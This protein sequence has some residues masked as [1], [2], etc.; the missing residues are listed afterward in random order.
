ME[1]L[2]NYYYDGTIPLSGS[3][4]W[5]RKFGG[6]EEQV[7]ITEFIFDVGYLASIEKELDRIV[8]N[9]RRDLSTD[10]FAE[11]DID[12]LRR[13]NTVD[14]FHQK[15]KKV[16][17]YTDQLGWF[18]PIFTHLSELLMGCR[19]EREIIENGISVFNTFDEFK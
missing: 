1:R 17:E 7:G 9:L 16:N 2:I 3:T 5:A 6:E 10:Q 11:L 12:A 4:S 19:I 13:C 8:D 18:N 14:E 15:E